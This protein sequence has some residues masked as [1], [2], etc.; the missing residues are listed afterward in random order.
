LP[1]LAAAVVALSLGVAS[2][3]CASSDEDSNPTAES[4]EEE[5]RL[6]DLQVEHSDVQ[7]GVRVSFT[8][9]GDR[10]TAQA[11]GSVESLNASLE[12]AEGRLLARWSIEMQEGDIPIIGEIDGRPF[13]HDSGH[14][15][16][17]VRL[18]ETPTGRVLKALAR[19]PVIER[20]AQHP[21]LVGMHYMALNSIDDPAETPQMAPPNTVN[22]DGTQSTSSAIRRLCTPCVGGWRYCV[23]Y[24]FWGFARRGSRC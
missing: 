12:D 3:G 1:G 20:R 19:S 11:S 8:V 15:D 14:P 4:K 7:R 16:E 13:V 23:Y 6:S 10:Y 18:L 21:S 2:L 5:A 22:A 17:L 24:Y 9:D